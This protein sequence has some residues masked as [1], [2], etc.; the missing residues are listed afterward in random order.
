[1]LRIVQN[2]SSAGAKAYF[3]SAD[4]YREGQEL[5]GSWHG[6]GAARLGLS[7]TVEK[8]DWDAL[9]DNR[10]PRTGEPLTVR[11]KDNRRVGYDLNFHVPKGLSLL[12]ALTGDG[13]IVEAFCLSVEET[14]KEL[15]AEAQTRVRTGGRD[16]DRTTGNLVWGT[17]VHT[18]SRPVD[19]TP[20]PHLHAHCF[21]FNATYD[22]QERRWKALQLGGVKRDAGYFE[23]AFHARLAR[24]VEELGVETVRTKDGWDVAGLD[25]ATLEKFSRRTR[26]IE[27]EAAAKGIVDPAAKAELG[28]KTR[29]RKQK[30]LSMDELRQT[31]RDRLTTAEQEGVHRIAGTLGGGP[32]PV[33]ALRG[34]E[35]VAL[36][37]DH[38][39]ERSSVVPERA[40]LATA[41][42]RGYG[43]SS[44]AAVTDAF[45]RRP[46][47]ITGERDGRRVATTHEVLAEETR[48]LDFARSGRGTCRP[49]GAADHAFKDAR[50][51]PGQRAAVLHVLTSPDRVT[52]IRGAAGVGKTTLMV[53]ATNAIEANGTRVLTFAPSA[54]ASRGVLR[55]EGFATADTVARLLVDPAMQEQARE[56]V[57]WVDEAGLLGTRTMAKLFDLADRI[58]ARI[59]LSGDR[60]Q[61][62]SVERGAALR[63]L[64]TEAGVV[65]AE[66]KDIQRQTG[67]YKA[68]VAALSEGRT[69]EGFRQL[70]AMGW[71]KE[72]GDDGERYQRLAAD[73]V[74][75]TAADGPGSTLV[76]SPTRREGQLITGQIRADLKRLGRL[77]KDERAFPTLTP[78][79]LTRAER[80]DAAVNLSA[81]DVLVYH[82]DRGKHRRGDRVVVGR[83]ALPPAADADCV[84]AYRPGTLPLATGDVVRV[85]ANGKTADGHR[86][87][88]GAVYAVAGFTPKGDVMLDNG[89]VVPAAFGHLA[90]GYCATS[91][92]S[93]GKSVKHVLV[94][95]SSAS[96]PASS[97]EQWYVS[98]SRGKRS[99]T[100]YTDDKAALRA[101]VARTDE[102]A[103]AT[104]LVGGGRHSPSQQQAHRTRALTLHRL[105]Q[106]YPRHKPP[107]RQGS[108]RT[109][110]RPKEQAYER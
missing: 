21:A 52:V 42:K 99:L 86:L 76:V 24:R 102:R 70:D 62:G 55:T 90:H 56:Q 50:L 5:L 92:A 32:R 8:A 3:S 12:Q 85:T 89:W 54:D 29:E 45:R 7:G 106:L 31:W 81:G 61:H 49:L 78:A 23:A 39:F 27:A 60:C 110:A 77:G 103:T 33:E 73:Y 9:C 43:K 40:V 63:L 48:M 10:D 30:Q 41:L 2:A 20:D 28:A 69:E 91:H 37:V 71:I 15:E 108:D 94:G 84:T 59:V 97:A 47:L 104:D 17:F 96:G 107:A 95:Q 100:V 58:D 105:K 98:A 79:H 1:M 38:C 14:M 68:A 22:D 44:L 25:K 82:R 93:Q 16:T 66:V 109:T 11:R 72:V 4:Y 46:D 53:E 34:A 74:A 18:T 65:P 67:K 87:N 35:A 19:G 57:L 51:N 80:A 36:A 6:K 101:A 64:E 13:R 26:L 88:N 75:L 83:D